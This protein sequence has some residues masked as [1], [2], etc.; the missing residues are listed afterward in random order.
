M[1]KQ[2][3]TSHT[4]Q[5]IYDVHIEK[6]PKFAMYF[7]VYKNPHAH[8]NHVHGKGWFQYVSL[9]TKESLQKLVKDASRAI[10][11]PF[12]MDLFDPNR[13]QIGISRKMKK[14]MRTQV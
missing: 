8:L 5:G 1:I 12:A 9:V 4:H 14:H 3:I 6:A 13:F 10:D 7:Y 11:F 2:K